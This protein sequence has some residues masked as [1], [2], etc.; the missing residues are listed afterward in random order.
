[1][2][3]EAQA[4]GVPPA[5]EPGPPAAEAGRTLPWASRGSAALPTP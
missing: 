5:Q 3:T 1:M 4:V 2:R